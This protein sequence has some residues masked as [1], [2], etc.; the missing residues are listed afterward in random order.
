MINIEENWHLLLKRIK[1]ETSLKI[2]YVIGSNDSGKTTFCRFLAENLAQNFS[3]V[4]IDGDPGQSLMGPP[5]TIGLEQFAQPGDEKPKQHLYFV[6]STTPRGHLLQTL[7]GIK[8]L[9][10]KAIILGAQRIVVD[11]CGFVL[12]Q[13]AREFQ[14][15]VIDLIRPH[16]LI[17]LHRPDENFRWVSNFKRH[18]GINLYR[19]PISPSVIPR[20]P[21]ERRDYREQKFKTYFE[22]AEPQQLIL[23][24]I[25][26]HGRIPDLRN[27]EKYRHI[28]VALCDA[29]N[30][31][32]SLGIVQEINLASKNIQIY[33]PQFDQTK[34]VFINFGSI[35]LNTE[36]Q[37][38]IPYDFV[39]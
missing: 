26:F 2:I 6:G 16:Y 15:R 39:I 30:Y 25:G 18:P 21:T 22:S 13:V 9:T 17:V 3:T 7:V 19:L 37:Q 36:G 33:A 4:Y 14:F 8:K 32:I 23:R 31:V 12:D 11:S 1:Q 35:Y 10:E 38:I 29:E 20:T 27:P 5:T 24:G 34:V 28:L